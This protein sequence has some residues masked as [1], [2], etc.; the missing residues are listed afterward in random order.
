MSDRPNLIVDL[1]FSFSLKIIA[2]TEVLE[3]LK[4]FNM[5]NQLFRSGT[6]I[7]ANVCE[8]QGAQS[9]SDF[10]HKCKVAYKEAEETR[11]WLMLCEKAPSYPFDNSMLEDIQSIIKVLGKIISSTN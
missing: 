5:A 2:F 9:K 3:N 7:G 8:A 6:S 1:T 11:Y 10:K 4:K